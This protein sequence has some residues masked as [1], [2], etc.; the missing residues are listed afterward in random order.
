MHDPVDPLL[1]GALLGHGGIGLYREFALPTDE[2]ACRLAGLLRA[3]N[4]A[5]G[6]DDQTFHDLFTGKHVKDLAT[7]RLLREAARGA[8]AART[9]NQMI[10][11]SRPLNRAL[12]AIGPDRWP[13]VLT[14]LEAQAAEVP[15][16]SKSLQQAQF[17]LEEPPAVLDEPPLRPP[18]PKLPRA[19][20]NYPPLDR[21]SLPDPPTDPT[22][23]PGPD[24][25][26]RG[27]PGSTPGGPQGSWWNDKTGEKLYPDFNHPAGVKPHWD[28]N[29]PKGSPNAEKGYRWYPD[30]TL[31]PK[32]S[33]DINPTVPYDPDNEA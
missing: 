16:L 4:A 10:E 26:W 6:L 14:G 29:P 21:P 5:S 13:G 25:V 7:T 22:K 9:I 23:P 19:Q 2:E 24:W 20:R 15:N 30:G 32:Q 33:I 17:F 1:E 27:R 18:S 12:K 11:A 3:W 31:E 28:W 8:V